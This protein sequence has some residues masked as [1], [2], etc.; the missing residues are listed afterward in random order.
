MSLRR[1]FPLAIL[2]P[3]HVL[4]VLLLGLQAAVAMA[5]LADRPTRQV[6]AHVD[7]RGTPHAAIHNEET[8]ALCTVRNATAAVSSAAPAP[9]VRDVPERPASG[10]SGV[11]TSRDPPLSN[12]TRAPPRVA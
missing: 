9:D 7:A 6:A 1:L 10:V 2:R 3:R 8:C 4:A 12:S 5:P 11:L